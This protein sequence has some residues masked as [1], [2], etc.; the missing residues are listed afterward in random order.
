[1]LSFQTSSYSYGAAE[2]D[3]QGQPCASFLND[4]LGLMFCAGGGAWWDSAACESTA[5]SFGSR[6]AAVATVLLNL[7]TTRGG[8]AL[9]LSMPCEIDALLGRNGS[10]PAVRSA[11]PL[12]RAP[13]PAINCPFGSIV[14]FSKRGC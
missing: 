1:M 8:H 9:Q 5:R 14:A 11:L 6:L 2:I 3:R 13:P 4:L 10:P 12:A 7:M